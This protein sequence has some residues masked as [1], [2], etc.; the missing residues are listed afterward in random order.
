[1]RIS[2]FVVGGKKLRD[3]FFSGGEGGLER[4]RQGYKVFMTF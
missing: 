2:L 3:F 1:M 4:G